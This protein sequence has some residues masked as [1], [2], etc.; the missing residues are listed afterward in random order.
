MSSLKI[1]VLERGFVYIGHAAISGAVI[2]IANAQC[3][4]RWG[5][6]RGLGQLALGG[7]QVNTRLDPAGSVAAPL[8]AV[9]HTIDC[10]EAKWPE[11]AAAE[12]V[13]A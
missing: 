6:E 1:V 11:F 13:A 8:S 10:D 2:T 7:K 9:I 4:R 12:S 3:I 5:T